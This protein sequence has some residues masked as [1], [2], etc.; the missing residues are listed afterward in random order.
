MSLHDNGD[1]RTANKDGHF[2]TMMDSGYIVL[3]FLNAKMW[4]DNLKK[5]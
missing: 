3:D 4:T 1:S 5:E 2:S